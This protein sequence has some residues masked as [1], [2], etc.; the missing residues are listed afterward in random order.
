MAYA[1]LGSATLG[2]TQ[3][4][5]SVDLTGY[6]ASHTY[7]YLSGLLAIGQEPVGGYSYLTK[8]DY[9]ATLVIG[10]EPVG[11]VGSNNIT[12]QVATLS[13][14]NDLPHGGQQSLVASYHVGN[15][16]I[17]VEAEGYAQSLGA[18]T[19]QG[20][21]EGGWDKTGFASSLSTTTYTGGVTHG[22]AF[23]AVTG[24]YPI[25]GQAGSVTHGNDLPQGGQYS[26]RFAYKQGDV[27]PKL[28]VIST[29]EQT[30]E[31]TTFTELSETVQT[32]NFSTVTT[33][34]SVGIS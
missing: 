17:G 31:D 5:W 34:T 4:G 32:V 14:G 11:D 20:S 29:I 6:S 12:G 7:N 18:S 8:N 19:Y 26:M 24:V 27:L 9:A 33:G 13:I 1:K 22:H 3:L 21:V 30:T 28:I 15:L 16:I 2:S 23:N 25:A 10:Q